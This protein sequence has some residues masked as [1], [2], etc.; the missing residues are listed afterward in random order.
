M[1][2]RQ[3]LEDIRFIL[4]RCEDALQGDRTPEEMA[5]MRLIDECA[6]IEHINDCVFSLQATQNW[7]TEEIEKELEREGELL[8]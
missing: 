3:A 6:E 1:K 5:T 8:P 4:K 7:L 2:R